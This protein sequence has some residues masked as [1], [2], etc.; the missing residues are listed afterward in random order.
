MRHLIEMLNPE[1]LIP[2]HGG[3]DITSPLIELGKEIGY[4][5]KKT[6]HLMSNGEHIIL[7]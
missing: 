7:N 1:H 4:K 6:S 2:S 5:F 3:Y